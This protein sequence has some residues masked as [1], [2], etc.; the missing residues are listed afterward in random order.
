MCL[1]DHMHGS[2]EPQW[3]SKKGGNFGVDDK[4]HLFTFCTALYLYFPEALLY[5]SYKSVGIL[6]LPVVWLNE[7]QMKN[8]TSDPCSDSSLF[9][10]FL[11]KRGIPM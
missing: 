2:W 7:T 9:L 3:V 4:S 6:T 1:K 10:P 5:P 8:D 11:R